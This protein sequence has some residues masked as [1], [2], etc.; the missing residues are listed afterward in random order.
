MEEERKSGHSG[1]WGLPRVSGT[2]LKWFRG[3]CS[4]FLYIPQGLLWCLCF[5]VYNTEHS[6]IS[7]VA[8]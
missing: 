3:F 4:L 5:Q 2:A 6:A 8:N 1:S 7:Q